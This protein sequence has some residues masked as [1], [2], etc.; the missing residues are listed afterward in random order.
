MLAPNSGKTLSCLVRLP[1]GTDSTTTR[2]EKI[3]FVKF[4]TSGK[5][6]FQ[7]SLGKLKNCAKKQ[8]SIKNWGKKLS[9]KNNP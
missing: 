1:K 7:E 2:W 6:V 9:N 4:H 8:M 3:K 5:K